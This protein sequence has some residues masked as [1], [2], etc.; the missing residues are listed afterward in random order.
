MSSL[1]RESARAWISRTWATL[2]LALSWTHWSQRRQARRERQL[3]PL[4]LRLLAQETLLAVDHQASLYQQQALLQRSLLLEALQPVALAMQRQ[5]SLA[6]KQQEELL[7]LLRLQQEILLEV[8][9]GQQHP[10]REVIFQQ[11]GQPIPR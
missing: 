1:S 6:L 9:Q 7:E 11:L 3:E 2:R 4:L 10:L 8:L 5:D